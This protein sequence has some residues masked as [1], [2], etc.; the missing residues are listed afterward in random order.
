[1]GR[2]KGNIMETVDDLKYRA[3]CLKTIYVCLCLSDDDD[4]RREAALAKAKK[5]YDDVCK[6][7][8]K[9]SQCI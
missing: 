3:D 1:M 7:L 2:E 8:K 4:P 9:V 5:A 6:K